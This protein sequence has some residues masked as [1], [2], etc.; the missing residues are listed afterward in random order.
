MNLAVNQKRAAQQGLGRL[1]AESDYHIVMSTTASSFYCHNCADGLGL[2]QGLTTPSTSPTP[3]QVTKAEKHTRPLSLSTGVHSVLLSGSTNAYTSF[4]N[5]AVREGFL[6]VE[7]PGVRTLQY[8][9]T[10]PIGIVYHGGTPYSVADSFR[11]VLSTAPGRA[12]GYPV[13]SSGWSGVRCN[14]CS[15]ALSSATASTAGA[16]PQ[17]PTKLWSNGQ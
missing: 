2:L 6:E 9:T 4:E 12:H 3:Y 7:P 13:A 5:L 11:R 17:R 15:V 14:S 10:A 8:Q 1:L 16:G